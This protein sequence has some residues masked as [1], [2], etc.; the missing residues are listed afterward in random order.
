MSLEPVVCSIPCLSMKESSWWSWLPWFFFDS[1]NADWTL[2]LRRVSHVLSCAVPLHYLFE[3]PTWR[4]KSSA[5]FSQ[6]VFLDGLH[7]ISTLSCVKLA[8]HQFITRSLI[9]VCFFGKKIVLCPA[10]ESVITQ[11]LMPCSSPFL[12]SSDIS[13][14]WTEREP[15]LSLL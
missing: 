11:P 9:F 12:F 13:F 10:M 2:E 8:S 7:L 14:S 6:L 1:A 4:F 15:M 3:T 5:M